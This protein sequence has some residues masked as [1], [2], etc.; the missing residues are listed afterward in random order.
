MAIKA[1]LFDVFGTL[2][3][4]RTT[5]ARDA[6][7]IIG[8]D[9]DWFAFA[10]AWRALYEPAMER[11]RSGERD[12]IPL[13]KLHRENLDQVL[14]DFDLDYLNKDARKDLNRI[15]HRLDPWPDVPAGLAKLKKKRAT[16]AQSNANIALMV[17]LSRHTGM[18]FDAILGAEVTGH[19]K[20]Q[21]RAYTKACKMLGFKA[22]RCMMVAAHNSDLAAAK[23]AGLKTAFIPRRTEY[24]PSQSTD[25]EP[26]QEWD[27]VAT[28]LDDLAEQ[29]NAVD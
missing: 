13:D 18:T 23:M 20:P 27:F 22:E 21:R 1:L 7:A 3:D 24:G 26:A 17:D 25:L 14:I 29:L 28:S 16:A 4:W 12:F 19:Y 15:W 10:D 11:V 5:V 9:A 2:V 6:Q 8:G